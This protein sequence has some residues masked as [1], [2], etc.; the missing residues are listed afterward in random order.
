MANEKISDMG[1]ASALD[2]TE[3]VEVVQ[4]GINKKTT[5]QDIANKSSG[6][7]DASETDKGVS[8]EA[9]A[10]ELAAGTATGSTGAKLFITP[11]K[12]LGY[13]SLV[14]SSVSPSGGNLTLT[15]NNKIE[16]TF[17]A[18]I[19][20]AVALVLSV[21]SPYKSWKL[22]LRVTGTRVVTLPSDCYMTDWESTLGRWNGGTK[23]LTLIGTTNTSF[24]LTGWYEN[25]I[26]MVQ[27]AGP[28]V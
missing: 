10:A 17:Y 28:Y 20:A 1:A 3:L 5:V 27:C 16:A 23:E 18:D 6:G 7:A 13:R 26:W 9:T 12:L 15:I 2:G 11:A 8:E 19:S 25:S 14:S 4:S 22:V 21:T 24:E